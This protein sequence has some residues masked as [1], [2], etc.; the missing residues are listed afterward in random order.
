MRYFIVIEDHG[1]SWNQARSRPEQDK[2]SEHAAFM[3]ALV[4]EGFV[5]LGGPFGDGVLV[6]LIINTD[7]EV[8]VERRLADDPWI[9]MGILTI[10][11]VQPWQILLGD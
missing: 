1:P 2:W 3:D 8:E 7:N 4:E 6:M 11:S 5:V 9:Q 10:A